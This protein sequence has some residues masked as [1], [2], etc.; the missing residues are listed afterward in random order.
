M[1]GNDNWAQVGVDNINTFACG[2]ADCERTSATFSLQ[3]TFPV[4][5]V[6]VLSFMGYFVFIFF[7]GIGL[8]SLPLDLIQTYRNRPIGISLSEYSKRKIA[9]ESRTKKLVEV[10]EILQNER[11]ESGENKGNKSGR[12][13]YTKF[14]QAVYQLESDWDSIQ[15][16]YR[17][18]GGNPLLYWAYLVLGILCAVY[19]ILWVLHIFI[20]VL[21]DPYLGTF[22]NR[23]FVWADGFWGLLGSALFMSFTFF[24]LWA[25]IKGNIKFG[26]RFMLIEIHPMK[27]KGTL[28]NSFLFN[29]GLILLASLAVVQF[30][31]TAFGPYAR[32]TTVF[33]LFTN[34]VRYLRWLSYFWTYSIL[35]M[36]GVALLATIY[37]SIKPSDRVDVEID[38]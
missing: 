6:A 9:I 36:M 20:Y 5:L 15:T 35:A 11:R 3:V 25:V 10:G 34:V 7:G 2:A 1:T 38:M 14:K 32:G 18:N 24:L 37:L 28:M 4:F 12:K 31:A 23:I 19:A 16:S 22:L 26:A 8:P 27:Y 13:T 17:Q 33:S 30:S 29:T 21:P